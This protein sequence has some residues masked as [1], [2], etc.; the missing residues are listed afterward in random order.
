[1]G[2]RVLATSQGWNFA[3]ACWAERV[4]SLS[5]SGLAQTSLESVKAS[6]FEEVLAFEE[7]GQKTRFFEKEIQGEI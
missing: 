1:M 4:F 7:F 3:C 6:F 2:F 5:M